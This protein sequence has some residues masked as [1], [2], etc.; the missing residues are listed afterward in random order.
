M[1]YQTIG[2]WI[3]DGICFFRV[4]APN[5]EG[6]GLLL[7]SGELWDHNAQTREEP[8]SRE[9]NGYWSNSVTNLPTG[10]LYRYAITYQGVTRQKLDPAARDLI[11]SGLTRFDPDN[12]NASIVPDNDST[13]WV[14]FD[15]PAFKNFIIYELHVGSFAGRNDHLGDK[16]IA[17]FLDVATKF[18][19]I[20]ELGFNAIE[21]LP[22]HEFTAD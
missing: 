4:W 20:R 5:A 21:L 10:T 1:S 11:H 22:V 9:A 8:L 19:Y 3:K 16:P 18:R 7:Q 2:A 17:R 12:C 6:V 15:T 13:D 14:P